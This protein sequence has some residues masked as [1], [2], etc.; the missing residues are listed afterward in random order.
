[1]RNKILYNSNYSIQEHIQAIIP[2]KEK[3]SPKTL[4][5]KGLFFSGFSYKNFDILFFR[6]DSKKNDIN[7]EITLDNTVFLAIFDLLTELPMHRNFSIS[8][9]EN[10]VKITDLL[11]D[12]ELI[13]KNSISN[14]EQLFFLDSRIFSIF[15]LNKKNLSRKTKIFLSN[16]EIYIFLD[17]K[18]KLLLIFK[19]PS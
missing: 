13:I 8:T 12:K 4:N 9:Y 11:L 2:K 19:N 18:E 15:K 14:K 1:M 7:I 5:F 16:N 10:E 3:G 17:R 6:E